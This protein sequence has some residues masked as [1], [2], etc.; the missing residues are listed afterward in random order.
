MNRDTVLITTSSF[1]RED[2]TP[3]TMIAKC[4]FE[5]V[6]NPFGRKLTEEEVIQL[7]HKYK[8]IAMIAGVEPLTDRVLKNAEGLKVISRCGIGLDNVDIDAA[9]KLGIVVTNTPDAPTQAVA[10]LTVGLI[11]AVLRN[12]PHMDR[13]LRDGKWERPMGTLLSEKT[14]GIIGCGRIGSAVARLLK[15]F[16]CNLIGFDPF[17]SYH[18]EI[19]LTTLEKL[20]TTAEIITIHVPYSNSVHYFINEDKLKL[21][22]PTAILVNTSRGGL[23]DENALYRVLKEKRIAG[24]CLDCY[25]QEPYSGPLRELSNVVLSAHVGSYAREARIKM[26]IEAV[27]NLLNALLK[28]KDK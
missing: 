12:V 10:E 23:V 18:P 11:L 3:L 8:P 20:L 22:R 16:N 27:D 15:G 21:M 28:G 2:N 13:A 17:L 24:A 9:R 5:P 25:E 6:L 19:H 26:E 7:F 1:G 4:G 14:V